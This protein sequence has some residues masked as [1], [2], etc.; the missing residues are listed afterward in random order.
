MSYL[1]LLKQIANSAKK[2]NLQAFSSDRIFPEKSV[3]VN[4]VDPSAPTY[5]TKFY[6]AFS[7]TQLTQ[8]A[9]GNK[10]Q[11]FEFH[12]NPK[13][14]D[15]YRKESRVHNFGEKIKE[16]SKLC[17]AHPL[18][19]GLF[20]ASVITTIACAPFV[21]F[22]G[23]FLLTALQMTFYQY[24]M[25]PLVYFHK[26]TLR[27]EGD[28]HYANDAIGD[29]FVYETRLNKTEADYLFDETINPSL[30]DLPA[31]YAGFLTNDKYAETRI[32]KEKN[33]S[34]Y[35]RLSYGTSPEKAQDL[36][37]FLQEYVIAPAEKD[38]AAGKITE[39]TI[40]KLKSAHILAMERMYQPRA[41]RMERGTA[42][43]VFI[44]M[45]K[46]LHKENSDNTNV[47]YVSD[48]YAGA[49]IHKDGEK[50]ILQINLLM[51]KSEF[52]QL[53]A[54]MRTCGYDAQSLEKVKIA[55]KIV[56]NN[57]YVEAYKQ[58]YQQ[59][60]DEERINVEMDMATF[61]GKPPYVLD[62]V[63]HIS[64][65]Q[66]E[67]SPLKLKFNMLTNAPDI[68]DIETKGC[69]VKVRK[70]EA[71]INAAR[72]LLVDSK[73]SSLLYDAKGN[74]LLKSDDPDDPRSNNA[75]L[76][77][78]KITDPYGR[79]IDRA[80]VLD[81]W[82][83]KAIPGGGSTHIFVRW[84]L[85][86][87]GVYGSTES[88]YNFHGYEVRLDD[89]GKSLE[90]RQEDLEKYGILY[91]RD[92]L[93]AIL[94]VD[95]KKYKEL[96]TYNFDRKEELKKW[97]DTN[98][99]E[100]FYD[101]I[102]MNHA[103]PDRYV[104]REQIDNVVNNI[105]YGMAVYENQE[106]L[107]ELVANFWRYGT[108]QDKQKNELR[109]MLEFEF[110]EKEQ[111]KQIKQILDVLEK[112]KDDINDLSRYYRSMDLGSEKINDT[113]E[114]IRI[115]DKKSGKTKEISG[116]N[117]DIKNGKMDVNKG[118]SN[119]MKLATFCRLY[120]AK[121]FQNQRAEITAMQDSRADG[122][123][124]INFEGKD[125]GEPFDEWL[126]S[127][128]YD[129]L[130][131]TKNPAVGGL[132][133]G[134]RWTIEKELRRCLAI[135]KNTDEKTN[136]TQQI[137][138]N[139]YEIPK[140]NRE[141][142]IKLESID[143]LVLSDETNSR[144]G[145][146]KKE[147]K[148]KY[149]GYEYTSEV[150]YTG[151]GKYTGLTYTVISTPK[152]KKGSARVNPDGALA[153]K[154][155]YQLT[156]VSN[157]KPFSDLLFAEELS[158]PDRLALNK[159]AEKYTM[160]V[161]RFDKEEERQIHDRTKIILD[162]V[163]GVIDK[164]TD[165][166]QLC[167]GYDEQAIQDEIEKRIKT[168]AYFAERY[169]IDQLDTILYERS[170][171]MLTAIETKLNELLS[172][173]EDKELKKEILAK[174]EKRWFENQRRQVFV[175]RGMISNVNIAS[176][177]NS[178]FSEK[179]KNGK[180]IAP[181]DRGKIL[182]S[183]K[184][185]PEIMQLTVR[186]KDRLDE[187]AAEVPKLSSEEKKVFNLLTKV[188]KDYGDKKKTA[189]GGTLFQ[190]L[191]F[192]QVAN[193]SLV[194]A[195][196]KAAKHE[197]GNEY[198]VADHWY[199]EADELIG[200]QNGIL[201]GQ[202]LKQNWGKEKLVLAMIDKEI[203]NA[204]DEGKVVDS[205]CTFI[206]DVKDILN[207][208][209][210]ESVKKLCDLAAEILTA[211]TAYR[212]DLEM[213]LI[214]EYKLP[215]EVALV[216]VNTLADKLVKDEV[217]G[218][219][220]FDKKAFIKNYFDFQNGLKGDH[221]S[222]LVDKV[223]ADY[224]DNKTADVI[225]RG[226]TPE[227]TEEPETIFHRIRY[228]GKVDDTSK[229][230]DFNGSYFGQTPFEEMQKMIKTV[231]Q[232]YRTHNGAYKLNDIWKEWQEKQGY[233][234]ISVKQPYSWY[235]GKEYPF[236]KLLNEVFERLD[237][238]SVKGKKFS[239]EDFAN[240]TAEDKSNNYYEKLDELFHA[241]VGAILPEISNKNKDTLIRVLTAQRTM[242]EKMRTNHQGNSDKD[243]WFHEDC[244]N[245]IMWNYKYRREDG[246]WTA[247]N[248]RLE[249]LQA[250]QGMSFSRY[251]QLETSAQ[252]SMT[253]ATGS[254][255]YVQDQYGRV[256]DQGCFNWHNLLD[257]TYA[258]LVRSTLEITE[259]T[260]RHPPR[261]LQK[262][263]LGTLPAGFTVALSGLTF[264]VLTLLPFTPFVALL[265][266]LP[267]VAVWFYKVLP[268][269]QD[270]VMPVFYKWLVHKVLE[271]NTPRN[272][273]AIRM[274]TDIS[275]KASAVE[276]YA[277]QLELEKSLGL[278]SRQIYHMIGMAPAEGE[279]D[280]RMKVQSPRWDLAHSELRRAEL[281][282]ADFYRKRIEQ[283][284]SADLLDRRIKAREEGADHG[285]YSWMTMYLLRFPLIMA[286]FSLTGISPLAFA[287]TIFGV[288][289]SSVYAV[290]ALT[291][292]TN[293]WWYAKNKMNISRDHWRGV[294]I[295]REHEKMA[296]DIS[297]A[298]FIGLNAKIKNGQVSIAKMPFITSQS[299]FVPMV[300]Y[301]KDLYLDELLKMN[302]VRTEKVYAL[303]E[304]QASKKEN[305]DGK[306]NEI[307]KKQ[308][309]KRKRNLFL[310]EK[311]LQLETLLKKMP[312]WN[313]FIVSGSVGIKVAATILT[314]PAL[315]PLTD[316][317]LML[318]FGLPLIFFAILAWHTL[319]H[320]PKRAIETLSVG[321]STRLENDLYQALYPDS[322]DINSSSNMMPVGRQI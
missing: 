84:A 20:S 280:V 78:E 62:N 235:R 234:T 310:R 281:L 174:I 270:D 58:S 24:F 188:L 263:V 156:F 97:L 33:G 216:A 52:T 160:Y 314:S 176:R 18:T 93:Y 35:I 39:E 83:R 173:E 56:Q 70:K 243:N 72:K 288:L 287:A 264:G 3:D 71:Q 67:T 34:A 164:K 168:D 140:I 92:I 127:I 177:I 142:Y 108:F 301:F 261:W 16:F 215:R 209:S 153:V 26:S 79:G 305:A 172:A 294:G 49:H 219:D 267:F 64:L 31:K 119:F 193:D 199:I 233:D 89:K 293:V 146:R 43:R 198:E 210:E 205:L 207:D 44:D 302:Y 317:L 260:N 189:S 102:S 107:T 122:T 285:R 236:W 53:L 289:F 117:M 48:D 186:D 163:M 245:P 224:I 159:L 191:A 4:T 232:W 319:W 65:A 147:I 182:N 141:D 292:V 190:Q 85:Q 253:D 63:L 303:N 282:G 98:I 21:Q 74:S 246:V 192:K 286:L 88:T 112:K 116:F 185:A 90:K 212:A 17:K 290:I 144:D 196:K 68:Y 169:H 125:A 296:E 12:K 32:G 251:N 217:V 139:A 309:K 158:N 61:T 231:M 104:S 81:E 295:D 60:K 143:K 197:K 249:N 320:R 124:N 202:E 298:T 106:K 271:R 178:L 161:S 211:E 203:K 238:V 36:D 27:Y 128:E 241:Y 283:G 322:N 304:L 194:K 132:T 226:M 109:K 96:R 75:L 265:I 254:L 73:G 13:E 115:K 171:K 95:K 148:D 165:K 277:V 126:E 247:V 45:N 227:K 274:T 22:G 103:N 145:F 206:K 204:N 154:D 55:Y 175:L 7:D 275:K 87:A 23:V 105:I 150:V 229:P 76:L 69:I 313:V 37:K 114:G 256:Q 272:V 315:F 133:E 47:L 200:K 183:S 123:I 291:A 240:A 101:W 131:D 41:G 5:K 113:E 110:Q 255:F 239:I 242:S 129:A 248:K 9:Y 25:I 30:K 312:K 80:V 318:G 257:D 149:E 311:S 213:L 269:L 138:G 46:D 1:Y 208:M 266:A 268:W 250:S 51:K 120:V 259:S 134:V 99:R 262:F 29:P 28:K 252:T 230:R 300:A 276:D 307:D 308:Y 54:D 50:D 279:P 155:A 223:L 57:F 297:N 121:S 6:G 14:Y 222:Y 40:N 77:V 94:S 179:D 218:L 91:V 59:L 82:L 237:D 162:A 170:V 10:N 2:I 135:K 258:H 273:S 278:F 244:M 130:H 321:I 111:Q 180:V 152:D 118:I 66:R 195:L 86:I 157:D 306:A 184:S 38:L 15:L 167:Y 299:V 100:R 151:I 137:K 166:G 136:K 11:I 8:T 181:A 42:D 187:L 221:M 228:S 19:M 316:V 220:K 284:W 214:S 201:G 225:R